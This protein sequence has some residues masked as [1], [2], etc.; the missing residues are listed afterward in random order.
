[1]KV[2]TALS[3][4]SVAAIATQSAAAK[5]DFFIQIGNIQGE[6]RDGAYNGWIELQSVEIGKGYRIIMNEDGTGRI[7]FGDGAHGRRLP[8]GDPD[9]PV[10]IGSVPNPRT[11][12]QYNQTN[13]EFIHARASRATEALEKACA[14]QTHF[15]KAEIHHV[16]EGKTSAKYVFY[17]LQCAA[18]SNGGSAGPK[19]TMSV[20]CV[21]KTDLRSG[22]A[23]SACPADSMKKDGTI[24]IQGKDITLKGKKILEN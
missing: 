4:I 8:G 2:I 3:A 1:M 7:Q 21:R 6:A 23:T 19:I 13:L 24:V 18:R 16:I 20:N 22:A 15:R 17:G 9:R 12:A 10:I 5:D 11:P 14:A